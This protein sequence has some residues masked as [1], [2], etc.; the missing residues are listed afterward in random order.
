MQSSPRLSSLKKTERDLILQYLVS[1]ELLLADLPMIPLVSGTLGCL[2]TRT[3]AE[4]N[5][6]TLLNA[7]EV[8]VFP[9]YA[10]A[11][12]AL[13]ELPNQV[14][15][16]LLAHY[17]DFDVRRL[18]SEP[19][20]LES[21]EKE[22][23]RLQFNGTVPTVDGIKWLLQFWAWFLSSTFASS[24]STNL[25]NLSIVLRSDLRVQR[26][27]NI[28][29]T[30]ESL[31]LDMLNILSRCGIAFL[32]PDFPPAA[33]QF[34]CNHRRAFSPMCVTDLLDYL[35]P[36]LVSKVLPD[37]I[38]LIRDHLSC[39]VRREYQNAWTAAYQVK[40]RSLPIFTILSTIFDS[41]DTYRIQQ[42]IGDIL[43]NPTIYF[44]SKTEPAI[45][46]PEL[47]NHLFI[48]MTNLGPLANLI[49]RG[50]TP[51]SN[52]DIV[53]LAFQHLS[54]QSSGLQLALVELAAGDCH[55]RSF[56]VLS[57]IK[58]TEIIANIINGVLRTP[59]D[60]VDPTSSLRALCFEQDKWLP[61]EDASTE[62]MVRALRE[63]GLL[64]NQLSREFIED[65]IVKIGSRAQSLEAYT[66]AE[67]LISLLNSSSFD[68]TTLQVPQDS[69]WLPAILPSGRGLC[70]IGRC[71]DAKERALFDRVLNVAD[72]SVIS[73]SFHQL[74][75]WN[76]PLPLVV[77][78]DQLQAVVN[79]QETSRQRQELEIIIREFG[80]RIDDLKLD[81]SC[82]D[83]LRQTTAGRCWIPIST[84]SVIVSSLEAVLGPVEN[85]SGFY[86]VPFDLAS[87]SGV[88]EFLMLMGC[89]KRCVI[90]FP[91]F[92]YV[93]TEMQPIER[94]SS[95][96]TGS[97]QGT[98]TEGTYRAS[99]S[100]PESN[101]P[102]SFDT[103]ASS[104]SR[105]AGSPWHI[106]RSRACLLRR[107]RCSCSII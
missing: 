18:D 9:S 22:F 27:N 31:S 28:V 56:G 32:H 25:M 82:M 41:Q 76:A 73:M 17:T 92:L 103:G 15:E 37:E 45:P 75:E 30:R 12:I 2:R 33:A 40:L 46:I 7:Q 68:C 94:G 54:T 86:S 10:S 84:A 11:A 48:D 106:T 44:V 19:I 91:R 95:I 39:T 26:M 21:I 98:F 60:V 8:L 5:P 90:S 63:L 67:Q 4:S 101:G 72:F 52:I 80:R 57:S 36:T 107:F 99:S 83:N 96:Q 59:G 3:S 1:E 16:R 93:L 23:H 70:P 77:L 69:A 53:E 62:R 71:R 74:L 87:C 78:A 50:A 89:Q 49:V 42:R 65:R 35:D 66:L 6:L 43:N 51:S 38:G 64:R 97:P 85:I 20:L 29:F 104:A 24:P 55:F 81:A 34:L 61:A 14:A 58:H 47:A 79:E 102:R 88:K 13:D 100:H 105:P